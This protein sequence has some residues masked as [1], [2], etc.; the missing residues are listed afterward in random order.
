MNK[1]SWLIY[2]SD[3][4]PS[5][6]IIAWLGGAAILLG[7]GITRLVNEM[8]EKE[9]VFTIK[10]Y[11]AVIVLWLISSVLPSRTTI[12]MITASEMSQTQQ[13]QDIINPA[14]ELLKKTITKE[15]EKVK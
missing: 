2:T 13:A 15:L 1:L 4:L 10:P 9:T 8:N 7:R 14:F 12:L 11:I 3:I 6:S 5:L